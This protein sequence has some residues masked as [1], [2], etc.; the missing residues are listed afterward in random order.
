MR[1]R[2]LGRTFR[3][4]RRAHRPRRAR[5]ARAAAG[6]G[7][8][9]FGAAPAGA[10]APAAPCRLL[11]APALTFFPALNRSPVAGAPRVQRLGD[12]SV[13]R[14]PPASNLQLTLVGTVRTPLPRLGLV[15]SVQWT[16]NATER[17]NPF[18]RYSASDLGA[19]YDRAN[20]V[21][22]TLAA[23][24]ALLRAADTRGW[25]DASAHVGDL[26]GPAQRPDDRSSYTHKL[27]LELV[28]DAYPFARLARVTWAHGVA[29]TVLLDHVATG[30]PHA[31]DEVPRGERRYLDAARPL[32]LLAGL[33]LPLAAGAP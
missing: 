6:F 16:P 5:G 17:G 28:T 8:A 24:G 20:A 2:A 30:L 1:E 12:G 27:D 26:Y 32:T 33:S 4:A 10:Q 31:G 13:H 25:F 29:V 7:L 19:T 9:L 22:L 3:R 11:C 23:T 15:G 21:T 14:I 18:T